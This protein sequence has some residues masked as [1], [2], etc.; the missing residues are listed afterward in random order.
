[1]D[2]SKQWQKGPQGN[3]FLVYEEIEK[4]NVDNLF[5]GGTFCGEV[6]ERNNKVDLD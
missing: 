6:L 4:D 5:V 1:M 2:N 3:W